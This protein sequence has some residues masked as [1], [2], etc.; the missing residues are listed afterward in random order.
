MDIYHKARLIL[1]LGLFLEKSLS[2]LN[3][4]K[5]IEIFWGQFQKGTARLIEKRTVFNL[6]N[7]TGR[8]DHTA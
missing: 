5:I 1:I 7:K 4:V 2:E 6:N 3:Y 8:L